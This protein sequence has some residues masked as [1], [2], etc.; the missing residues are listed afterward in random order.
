MPQP[1]HPTPKTRSF[2]V[3]CH[4]S[5]WGRWSPCSISCGPPDSGLRTR[6][7][8]VVQKAAYGGRLCSDK[9]YESQVCPH[10]ANERNMKARHGSK[11]KS[12]YEDR[13]KDAIYYCPSKLTV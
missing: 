9:N 5:E 7:R 3:H 12:I 11:Y 13:I 1:R 4:W 2:A 8:H 10:E 6:A